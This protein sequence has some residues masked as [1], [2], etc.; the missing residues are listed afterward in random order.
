MLLDSERRRAYDVTL[1]PV[2]RS[3]TEGSA[4]EEGGGAVAAVCDDR[5][6]RSDMALWAAGAALRCMESR[7]AL[8]HRL[9]LMSLRQLHA[10][11]HLFSR[12]T[13]PARGHAG[14][15]F[16]EHKSAGRNIRGIYTV[17]SSFK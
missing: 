5:R 15:A 4:A 16:Q 14:A 3:G 11:S 1:D 10:L 12:A 13:Y 2:R 17:E 8:P 9:R 6:A 7:A